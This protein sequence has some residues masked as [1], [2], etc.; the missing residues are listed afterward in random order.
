MSY[1]IKNLHDVEDSA[2]K[3]GFAEMGEAHFARTELE[4]ESTGV[5]YHVLRPGKRQSFGHRHTNAEEV[6]VILSGSGRVKLDEE[7]VEVSTMQALRVAPSVTRQFEAGPDG[8]EYL[9][10]GPHHEK[11]GELDHEFWTD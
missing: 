11:D 8:L 4:A 9:V 3:F 5:T 2:P 7:I 10:F 6:H 1:T